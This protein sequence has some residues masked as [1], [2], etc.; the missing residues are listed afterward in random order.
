MVVSREISLTLSLHAFYIFF[1][2]LSIIHLS[3]CIFTITLSLLFT[4]VITYPS[5]LFFFSLEDY[6]R[7]REREWEIQYFYV[8]SY[9]CT[10][11]CIC[12]CLWLPLL[13]MPAFQAAHKSSLEMA[14]VVVCVWIC[15]YSNV[16]SAA[17]VAFYSTGCLIVTAPMLCSTPFPRFPRPGTAVKHTHLHT[18]CTVSEN[19]WPCTVMRDWLIKS[20]ERVFT[21]LPKNGLHK[22]STQV[23]GEPVVFAHCGLCRGAIFTIWRQRRQKLHH[24]VLTLCFH[25]ETED[26]GTTQHS[27]VSL[28]DLSALKMNGWVD[29]ITETPQVVMQYS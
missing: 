28:V 16:P 13:C 8:L 2:Q 29:T 22:A 6:K 18:R 14:E 12:V 27:V 7:E 25:D 5:C 19:G 17:T 20:S 24:Y 11:E 15:V 10:C 1:S 23:P 21:Q 4:D 9:E 3:I 26:I